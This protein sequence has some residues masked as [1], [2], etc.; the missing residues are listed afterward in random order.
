MDDV[1]SL[2]P[3]WVWGGAEQ[4]FA[5]GSAGEP[6]TGKRNNLQQFIQFPRSPI[7]NILSLAY[8]ERL[9]SY[10]KREI[11]LGSSARKSF[12]SSEK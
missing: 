2:F 11:L 3:A 9:V 10:I 1:N 4:G 8:G 12:V 5:P 7:D 6:G